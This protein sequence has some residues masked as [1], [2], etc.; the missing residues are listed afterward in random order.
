MILVGIM[1]LLPGLCVGVVA[2]AFAITPQD[3]VGS[4]WLALLW[5]ACFAITAGGIALIWRAVRRLRA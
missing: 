2:V 1:L 3:L 4:P 5:L